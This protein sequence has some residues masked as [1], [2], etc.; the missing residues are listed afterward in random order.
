[1][2]QQAAAHRRHGGVDRFEQRA[3][4][5]SGAERLH[6]LEVPAR[7]VVEP[8][9]G[10]DTAD[11]WPG[12]VG[13]SGRLQLAQ[14]AEQ[15]AGGAERGRVAGADTEPIERG[16]AEA[17]RHLFAREVG[18]ELPG[19]ALHREARGRRGGE[20]GGGASGG[21]HHFGRREPRERLLDP[22]LVHRLQHELAGAEIDRR[23]T[24]ASF[25]ACGP[26]A[27][28]QLFLAPASHPS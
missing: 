11:E 14:V 26:T 22:R 13:K 17:A 27:T 5:G 16:E 8:E 9:V 18:I 25:V 12:E 10:I 28:I 2:A 24:R 21:N 23:E 19:V 4:A 15:R 1:M 7:H 6:Q 3:A 20:V